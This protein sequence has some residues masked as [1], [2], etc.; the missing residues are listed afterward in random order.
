MGIKVL[1]KQQQSSYQIRFTDNFNNLIGN[2]AKKY[3][4]IAI[5]TDTN[6]YKLYREYLTNKNVLV[7]KIKPGEQN[8]SYKTKTHIEELLFK[9]HFNRKSLLVVV[10]GGVVGDLGAF[11]ASTYMRGID[12]IHIPTSLVAI[13]DSSIGGKTGINNQFGKNLVGTFY[14]PREI[15]INRNFLKTL[16]RKEVTQGLAE[17][18]KYGIISNKSL[19][20][21][22][23]KANK[24]LLKNPEKIIN[25]IIKRCI[26]IKVKTV[27]EDFKES[28]KRVILNFGH[29][30]GHAL[31]KHFS[32][33]KSHGEC[34]GL[35]MLTE[36]KIAYLIKKLSENDYLR[37]KNLLDKFNLLNL[38]IH[39]SDISKLIH[40]MKLDKK[41]KSSKITFSLPNQIGSMSKQKGLYST[42]IP[43]RIII[44]AIKEVLDEFENK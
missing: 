31:E 32:Y 24:D 11:V 16:P 43:E 26:T 38:K 9:R 15:I 42:E 17:I 6:I 28:N 14:N 13:V 5:L 22:L 41:N 1:H 36:S 34:I 10:G 23:E 33:K 20:V 44:S 37:I 19:F 18:I 35:G 8:K 3:E 21:L 27:E 7:I 12:L 30:I 4:K 2:N 25:S 29:T 39:K 40:Y